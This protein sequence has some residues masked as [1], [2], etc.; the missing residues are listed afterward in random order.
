MGRH[1]SNAHKC[2][3]E[4]VGNL[5]TTRPANPQ[6][7]HWRR[8]VVGLSCLAL[9]L[10]A[11]ANFACTVTVQGV[12]PYAGG[13]LNVKHSGR[14]DWTII[15]NLD[16]PY[17]NVNTVSPTV[18][19]SWM[20]ILLRAKKNNSPV[21]FWFAGAGSCATLGTYSSSQVPTYVGEVD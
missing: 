11:H 4:A 8:V 10:S 6:R 17:T 15:C 1:M 7:Y 14:N 3:S 18:C 20:V 12:L 9:S 19:A 2:A 21:Q 16:A 5:G 13:A